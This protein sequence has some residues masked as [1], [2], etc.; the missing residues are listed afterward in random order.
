MTSV[1]PFHVSL[2]LSEDKRRFWYAYHKIKSIREYF[3]FMS[4]SCLFT[5]LHATK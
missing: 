4:F 2:Y 1:L 5:S 3:G